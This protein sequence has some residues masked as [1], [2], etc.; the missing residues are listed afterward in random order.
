MHFHKPISQWS[1]VVLAL[2]IAIFT[3]DFAPPVQAQANTQDNLVRFDLLTANFGWIL[4][5]QHLFLTSDAGQTWNEISPALPSGASIEDV[6]FINPDTGWMLWSTPNPDGTLSFQLSHTVD[7]G[8]T[9]NTQ[10]LS[11]FEAGDPTSYA[12]KA[13]MGWFDLQHG[14]ITIKQ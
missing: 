6:M 5:G 7:H 9:W 12:E 8:G 14:W 13:E 2:V 3:A 1:R 4:L 11:L 10:P